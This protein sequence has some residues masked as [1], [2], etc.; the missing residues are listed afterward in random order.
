MTPGWTR[1]EVD[2]VG[3]WGVVTGLSQGGRADDAH[4]CAYVCTVGGFVVCG[5]ELGPAG[6]NKPFA[7]R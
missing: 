1:R 6:R 5:V 4:I 7:G 3:L 2:Q